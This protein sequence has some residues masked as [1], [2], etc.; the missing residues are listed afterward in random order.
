MINVSNLRIEGLLHG[1]SFTLER[2]QRLGIIGESGSGKSLTALSI[3]GLTDL[4]AEG[5]I[6]VDGVEM[7]G[8]S[9]RTRRRVRGSRVAMVFQEPMTALDPLKK[10]SLIHI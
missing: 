9:E 6:T 5:S 10:L 1:I 2:G 3:M 7:I 8:T 4:P